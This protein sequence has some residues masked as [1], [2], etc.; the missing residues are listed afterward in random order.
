MSGCG[1]EK[2]YRFTHPQPPSVPYFFH[3]RRNQWNQW[4]EPVPVTSASNAQLAS[5]FYISRNPTPTAEKDRGLA[6]S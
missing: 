5:V 3:P 2:K 4:L 6:R 1:E